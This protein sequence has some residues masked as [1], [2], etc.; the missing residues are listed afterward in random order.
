M[1]T[2]IFSKYHEEFVYFNDYTW[3]TKNIYYTGKENYDLDYIKNI[4]KQ[5]NS[6]IQINEKMITSNFYKYYN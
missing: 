6:K 1:G 5:V 3:N 2:D 4:S